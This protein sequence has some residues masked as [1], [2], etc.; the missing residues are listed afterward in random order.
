[1]WL[2]V[3]HGIHVPGGLLLLLMRHV[4]VR[5]GSTRMQRRITE[6]EPG[7]WILN[8]TDLLAMPHIG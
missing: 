6:A 2:R 3:V 8:V 4:G 7:V 1:M 5:I